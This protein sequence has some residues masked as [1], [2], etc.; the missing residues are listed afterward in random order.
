[1]NKEPVDGDKIGEVIDAIL[2]NEGFEVCYDEI[3][4]LCYYIEPLENAKLFGLG[5]ILLEVAFWIYVAKTIYKRKQRK[6]SI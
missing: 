5:L 6:R 3:F 2:N 4:D 1:M